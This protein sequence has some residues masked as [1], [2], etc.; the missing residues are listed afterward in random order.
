LIMNYL[1]HDL[2]R[3]TAARFG[4]KP[5]VKF[6]KEQISYDKLNF[7]S[8]CLAFKLSSSGVG[9]GSRVGIYIDKSI[10]AVVAIFG[11]LKTGSA[12]VPLDPM[13][14]A[15]RIK[16]I[17]ENCGIEHVISSSKKTDSLKQIV[18]AG[19]ILKYIFLLDAEKSATTENNLAGVNT[20]YSNQI[21]GQ[22]AEGFKSNSINDTATAYILYTSGSTGIPKGVIISH[23]AS[24][25][26]V[27]WAADCV[28]LTSEDNVSS[29]APFHFDLS[30][31]DIYATVKVGAT[32]HLVPQGLS[33]FPSSLADFIEHS[34]ISVWYS[35]P[36]ILIQ[37]LL[38]GN[39]K[40]RNLSMLRT[41]IFAG[42]V[43]PVKHLKRLMEIISQTS[44]Y[45]FYGPTETNVC[46]YYQVA[47]LPEEETSI[48]IGKPCDGQKLFIVG[49]DG[50]PVKDGEMGELYVD[51]P[52]LMDGYWADPE[53]TGKVLFK[54]PF[55]KDSSKIY[56]TGDIV[57]KAKDGN[58]MYHGRRDN[59]IKSSGY[60]I[61]LGEI[62]AVLLSH[63]DIEEAVA[64]GVTDE[65]IGK[66]IIAFITTK[67]KA[68]FDEQIIKL[69]C[70]K[71]LPGYM[72]P[73]KISAITSFPRT[74]TGK[75]DRKTLEKESV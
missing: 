39:L 35:V 10:E 55:L 54:N 31:F 68:T 18:A 30:V 66:R 13:S 8:D 34:N 2:L 3:T 17:I 69:F 72:I 33:V 27:N 16:L 57:H 12:Y 73:E 1:L 65:K 5:A 23:K 46:T 42:E 48:P 22:K 74:S 67:Q 75:I 51:G 20:I 15:S 56:K 29:H 64:I 11:I 43:F 61:E 7:L 32:L 41:I 40:S 45:N 62:E 9:P 6:Q 49:E 52:T 14:P 70:S 60:R 59:M 58:L 19:N 71:H 50:K 21:W 26:F 38:Y 37:L 63:P 24:L 25:A 47:S 44:Y 4:K 53:K 36:T 28:K